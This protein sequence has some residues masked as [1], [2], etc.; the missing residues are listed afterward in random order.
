MNNGWLQSSSP[1][2]NELLDAARIMAN[3]GLD[4][5]ESETMALAQHR[6]WTL[7][8][9]E[10]AGRRVAAQYGIPLVGSVG[11]L[12][13]GVISNILTSTDADQAINR[14]RASRQRLP[15][16]SFA[17]FANLIETQ[18]RDAFLRSL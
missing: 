16:G 1:D 4:P 18:G 17:D 12:Y 7:I 11:I 6:G 3:F 15:I 8:C 13:K 9:D 5:G 10:K 2:P 14:M